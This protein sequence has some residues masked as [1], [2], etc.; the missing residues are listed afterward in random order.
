MHNKGGTSSMLQ[1][2]QKGNTSSMLTADASE[3][4]HIKHAH[5]RCIRRVTRQKH[6]GCRCIRR[7]DTTKACSLQMH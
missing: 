6:A 1:M 5:C 3:E 4:W 2:H 7:G